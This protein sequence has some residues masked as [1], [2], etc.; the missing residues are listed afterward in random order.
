MH[1]GTQRI[2]TL[3]IS[4]AVLAILAFT[5]VFA[6][7]SA[8]PAYA[9]G[10]IVAERSA[11]DGAFGAPVPDRTDDAIRRAFRDVLRREPTKSELRR[12]RGR[13]LD[14]GW[15]ERDVVDDLRGRDDYRSYSGRNNTDVDRVIRRAYDDILHRA[16]DQEG[17]RTYRRN[18]LNDG[19][20]EQDVRET[21]R[22]SPEAY[23]MRDQYA[24]T[25]IR[26]AYQ[27]I[28]RRE[29]D[30]EGLRTYRRRILDDGWDEQDV[31]RA[32]RT[33]NERR[34]T[35]TQMNRQRAEE[36]VQR[37]YRD[38]LGREADP[39]GL[40]TYTDRVM[41]DKWTEADVAKALRSSNEARST[42]TTMTRQRAE[43]MVKR[44]YRDV[45]G[46]EADASGLRTFTDRVMKDKW[47]EADVAKAL[48]NSDEYRNKR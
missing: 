44:V 34:T 23:R 9:S 19:W 37:A 47:T 16:P 42:T 31:R 21:L 6:V 25:V 46:R 7:G 11:N 4:V 43:E 30:S 29:P 17:L 8:A 33:S 32:L 24:D 41:R 36:M 20:T 13:M 1:M 22:N 48:R 35:T 15:S 14:D 12:Y 45:L 28:L 26:R 2:R 3:G 18:M 39:N 27:D 5:A 40:R 10:P 38:V